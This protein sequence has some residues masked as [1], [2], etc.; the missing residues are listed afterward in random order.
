VKLVWIIVA[1]LA[2]FGAIVGLRMYAGGNLPFPA[3][4]LIKI[5]VRYSFEDSTKL[6]L[7]EPYM[8]V[9]AMDSLSL[10]ISE[11]TLCAHFSEVLF[12]TGE[13][14]W[15]ATFCGTCLTITEPT[16]GYYAMNPSFIEF[17][18]AYRDSLRFRVPILES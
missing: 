13:E 15:R 10:K 2:T 8:L 4:E 18:T 9:K 3:R 5:E 17:L 16:L 14:I 6:V 11:P 7:T 12:F 1:F